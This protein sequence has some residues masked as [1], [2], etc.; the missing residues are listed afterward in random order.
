MT[1]PT[2]TRNEISKLLNF[3]DNDDESYS[4]SELLES[5]SP[6]VQSRSKRFKKVKEEVGVINNSNSSS[7][8]LTSS[9]RLETSITNCAVWLQK[10]ENSL[11]GG[12]QRKKAINLP[13]LS[14]PPPPLIGSY[15][16]SGGGADALLLSQQQQMTVQSPKD[17]ERDRSRQGLPNIRDSHVCSKLIMP[18]LVGN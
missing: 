17:K 1:S 15:A 4:D 8:N 3:H 13:D 5:D 12:E 6:D 18:G 7:L 10:E 11:V 9:E 16:S 14:Q 2:G